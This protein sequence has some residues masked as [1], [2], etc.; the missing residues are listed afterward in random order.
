MNLRLRA[1]AE[2]DE[3]FSGLPSRYGL[4]QSLLHSATSVYLGPRGLGILF[5]EA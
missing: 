3:D 4:A 5:I 2:E 1:C